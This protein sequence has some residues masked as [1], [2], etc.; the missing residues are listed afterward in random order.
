V[1]R[2]FKLKSQLKAPEFDEVEIFAETPGPAFYID[3]PK[4]GQKIP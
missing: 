2:G 3:G 1:D 4:A